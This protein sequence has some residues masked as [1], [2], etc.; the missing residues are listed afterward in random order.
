MDVESIVQIAGAI[1]ILIG[2]IASQRGLMSPQSVLYLTLNLIGSATLAVL[3]AL[4][5]D[6]GFLLLEGVWALVSAWALIEALRQPRTES[7]T[8]RISSP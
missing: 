7:S 1:L 8:A 2:F 6:W 4:D 5:S 3:A